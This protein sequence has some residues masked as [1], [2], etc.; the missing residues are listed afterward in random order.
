MT[1]TLAQLRA[2]V[3]A[4]DHRSF[5]EAA[6]SLAIS[7][8]AVSHAISALE[9]AVGGRVVHRDPPVRPTALGER[10]LPHARA[11]L[12]SVGTLEDAARGPQLTGV[13]RLATVTT[14]YRAVLPRLLR[15]WDARLPDVDVQVFE[16]DDGEMSVWLEGGMVDA[17]VL[18]DPPAIPTGARLLATDDYR[19]VVRRDHP[20]ARE[21]SI[22]LAEL[23]EDPLIVSGGGY[24]EQIRELHH[25]AGLTFES[26]R[27]V[28]ELATLITMVEKGL[29]VSI[30]PSLGAGMLGPRLVMLPLTPR[31]ERTLVMSGPQSRPWHPLVTALLEELEGP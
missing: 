23:L 4:V 31:L 10:V 20:F 7:Q 15:R 26:R 17:A 1:V 3:A 18:V 25:L 8:S 24:E 13:V 29:G 21:R 28:R 14:V 12:A 19:A 30:L 16:G 2:L 5:T 6:A 11:T 22:S 9:R 27:R